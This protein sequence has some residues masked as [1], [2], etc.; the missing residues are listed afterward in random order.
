M[1]IR[2]VYGHSSDMRMGCRRGRAVIYRDASHL[3]TLLL[4]HD[5]HVLVHGPFSRGRPNG[6]KMV[7]EDNFWA[8]PGLGNVAQRERERERG[9][10]KER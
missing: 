7:P 5:I 1:L 6:I 9:G 3:K 8:R 2:C 4:L 10:E